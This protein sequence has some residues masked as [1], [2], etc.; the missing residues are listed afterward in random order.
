MKPSQASNDSTNPK[1]I[2]AK[3]QSKLDKARKDAN[4]ARALLFDLMY[5]EC[6]KNEAEIGFKSAFIQYKEDL[7]HCV[8]QREH[9]KET[10]LS[11][12][13]ENQRLRT[14]VDHLLKQIKMQED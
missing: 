1:D 11:L 12:N 5:P 8:E 7:K 10:N 14:L 9:L 6:P 4:I 13:N 2:I 3:L